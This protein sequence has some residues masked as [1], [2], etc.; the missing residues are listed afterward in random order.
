MK[1]KLNYPLIFVHGMFGWGEHEGL[2]NYIP[3]WGATS[4][5]IT[6]HM[7]KLGYEAHAASVGPVSSAWD[8]ACELYAQ[9]S[10]TRVDYGKVHSEQRNHK[11]FGREYETPLIENWSAENKVHLIGHSFGGT[12]IRMLAH[13][14]TYGAPEE[15]EASGDEVSPLFTGGKGDWICS[16]TAIC[17]P[18]NG[19]AAHDTV[20]RY[21][22]KNVFRYVAYLYTGTLGRTP[23]N[24]TLVDFHLEQFGLSNTPG[25]KDSAPFTDAVRRLDASN[26][27]VEYDMSPEGTKIINDRI[28]ISPNICYFS[29]P[30]NAVKESRSGKRLLP[31]N[32]KFPFLS[33]TSA[34]LIKDIKDHAEDPDD[35]EKIYNDGLV[36]T[37]SA[38]HPHTEPHCLW[39]ET[40]EIKPGVW[41]VMPITQGDHGSAIGLF[42][43]KDVT[44]KF[45]EDLIKI[46]TET[47]K[48]C[49]GL[50]VFKDDIRITSPEDE[51]ASKMSV[52]EVAR[53]IEWLEE[54]GHAPEKINECIKYISE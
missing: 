34:L 11:Q 36:D 26:D 10:G 27:Q 22:L 15:M 45:Y 33:M 47:E 29:Y 19:T 41:H 20:V 7:A 54:N 31:S 21:R 52:K 13:L 5:N 53:L 3:Y 49:S 32:T 6:E 46:L 17:S 2:N 18:L 51:E 23:L 40:T 8:R 42:E 44:N 28:K 16:L 37:F 14:L 50:Q 48:I 43:K 38:T 25:Q 9:L 30:Y 12:T 1:N 24:G 35:I 4:G 39:E